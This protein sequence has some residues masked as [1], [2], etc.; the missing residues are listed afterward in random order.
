MIRAKRKQV[1]GDSN[2]IELIPHKK[3]EGD[4]PAV[5]I[6]GHVHWLNLSTS[7]ME[8]RPLDSLWETS[9]ENWKIDCTP[10][11]YRM[12][13]GTE[14]LV[15]IRSKTWDMVSGLLRP[16][17]MPQNLLV[18][19]SPIDSSQPISSLQLSV[20]L[21]RYGLSFYVDEDGDLQSYNIRG[22]VYDEDQS[23]GTLFGLVN[24]LVLRPKIRDVHAVELIPRC[25]LIPEG[26][27]SFKL[28]GHHV[29]V[30]I[31]TH[32]P[33]LRRVTYQT[34][35][36]DTDMGCLT[37][38][39]SLANMLYRAY[40]H[41]LTSG[42]SPD[43]LTGRSGTEEAL[44]L[45]WSASCWS[46]TRFSSR[47]AVLLSLIA[48]ICPERRSR[49]MTWLDLPSIAQYHELYVVAN[50]IKNH[51]E[52]MLS[53]HESQP[54][55]LFKSFP[56]RDM[57]LLE[58][59]ALRAA[60]LFPPRFSG[61]PSGKILDVRYSAR[62]LVKDSSGEQRAYTAATLVHHWT[63]SATTTDILSM[64]VSWKG[65]VSGTTTLSLRYDRS[66]LA[67]NLPLIWLKAYE[68]L[69]GDNKGK[70]F[71]LL[72]SLPAMAYAFLYV[73]R[74]RRWRVDY[75]LAPTRTMLAVPYRAKDVPALRA[76]F[77]HPDM[78]I[79][80]TCLSYY[81]SG[82]T[83]EQLRICFEILLKQDDPSLDYDLWVQ[84]C[85]AV[86]D[87]LRTLGGVNIKSSEQW[88]QS[89]FPLFKRNRATVDFYLSS[90]VFPKAAKEFPSKLS[91]SGWD[92][93]EKKERL[94]TGKLMIRSTI[95]EPAVS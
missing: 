91:C 94:L 37:G 7:V 4:L 60:Y 24:Q 27:I 9:S 95:A 2:T 46:I 23:V 58:R 10:G 63:A 11:Q 85:S 55:D 1:T 64:M 59:S 80:L 6:E 56:S 5:L 36:V 15:D 51:C 74:E 70:R 21:L 66:W 18:S 54:S 62:D 25:V 44:S 50:G 71:Q 35:R 79:I 86:P 83:E 82:L 78:A 12:Q 48:S 57:H 30:E 72:F 31:N 47:E 19:V 26:E 76:E 53:F 41:A 88:N 75:G 13:K 73:F 45:L 43:P 89:L 16:F 17:D 87:C 3:L 20:V 68:L 61:Q 34:Y 49:Y 28:D 77:G 32:L 40:L 65:S 33:P 8:V 69:R 38:N 22:M 14:F 84:D 93:A 67:P 90:V 42:C 29:R 92:L 39:V 52:R 81:Y